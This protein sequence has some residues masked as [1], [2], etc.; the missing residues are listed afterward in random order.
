[1]VIAE[2]QKNFTFEWVSYGDQA[3]FITCRYPACLAEVYQI[4]VPGEKGLLK[5][6]Y[7]TLLSAT[8]SGCLSPADF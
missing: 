3:L 6:F 7:K 2:K 5:K 8:M 4:I 1:M